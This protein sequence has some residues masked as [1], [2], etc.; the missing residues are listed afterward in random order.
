MTPL[1]GFEFCCCKIRV[2]SPP[3]PFISPT[4]NYQ[5]YIWNQEGKYV[6]MFHMKLS[7]QIT[8]KL[9]QSIKKSKQNALSA[10]LRDKTMADKLMYIS[11]VEAQNYPFCRLKLVFELKPFDTRLKKSTKQNSIKVN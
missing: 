3:S 5:L 8:V 1:P 4:G 6:R 2:K 10:C 7:P 9:M 11:N